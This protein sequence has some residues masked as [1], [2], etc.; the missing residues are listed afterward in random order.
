M[1]ASLSTPIQGVHL[2]KEVA[3]FG[4]LITLGMPIFGLRPTWRWSNTII[5]AC[6]YIRIVFLSSNLPNRKSWMQAPDDA[7]KRSRGS[8]LQPLSP[9]D[10]IETAVQ[11]SATQ[12]FSFQV[13]YNNLESSNGGK[14][15]VNTG[16]FLLRRKACP[17]TPQLNFFV[18]KTDHEAL[19]RL[20]LQFWPLLW[21]LSTPQTILI[22]E[23]TSRLG[24]CLI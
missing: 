12:L 2:W 18:I 7:R 23:S 6:R 20:N 4:G 3:V 14:P 13:S 24:K 8:I 22:V 5:H 1:L 15:Q 21:A 9:F 16:S 19:N 10:G 11:L 17:S